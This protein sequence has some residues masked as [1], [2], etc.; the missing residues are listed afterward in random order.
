[1]RCEKKKWENVFFPFLM[2]LNQTD[3]LTLKARLSL[4][5]QRKMKRKKMMYV[6][7]FRSRKVIH[8]K[9]A[10][11]IPWIKQ[12]IFLT[13]TFNFRRIVM[14]KENPCFQP[15]MSQVMTA[16]NPDPACRERIK[17]CQHVLKNKKD[18]SVYVDAADERLEK[19][20]SSAP[21][22]V[23]LFPW[24]CLYFLALPVPRFFFPM[25]AT[26]VF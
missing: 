16:K 9:I 26:S 18:F 5:V 12:G 20:L 25:L 11:A 13:L 8:D 4:Q 21:C 2:K 6:S 23:F 14:R 1:M 15:R 19:K 3:R 10:F 22:T 17:S 7:H 24:R